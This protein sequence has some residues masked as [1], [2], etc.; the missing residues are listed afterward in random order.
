MLFNKQTQG[1]LLVFSVFERMRPS[2]FYLMRGKTHLIF[3]K[4]IVGIGIVFCAGLAIIPLST[5][6]QS[7]QQSM[8]WS[9]SS[10]PGTQ[11]YLA[12]RKS[13]FLATNPPQASMQIFAD[14]RYILWVN[15][16]YVLRGP[17]RFDWHGP[18]YDTV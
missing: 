1:W 18:Q 9:P 4:L 11:V 7:L 6:A 16:R 8:I 12:F 3:A 2:S 15:G 14:S 5:Q 10:P 17:C 13:F